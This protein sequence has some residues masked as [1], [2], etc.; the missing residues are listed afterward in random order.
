M[1]EN[2]LSPYRQVADFHLPH[3]QHHVSELSHMLLGVAVARTIERLTAANMVA[4]GNALKKEMAG[5]GSTSPDH[6]IAGTA[7]Q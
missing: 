3:A 1:S 5:T 4:D 7:P 6:L 2:V